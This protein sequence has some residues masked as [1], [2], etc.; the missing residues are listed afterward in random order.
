MGIKPNLTLDCNTAFPDALACLLMEF[1]R[2]CFY[3]LIPLFG[4]AWHPSPF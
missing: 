3:S 2:L 1:G 4:V